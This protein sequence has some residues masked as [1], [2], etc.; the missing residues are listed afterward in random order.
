M[1]SKE[2]TNTHAQV[3][4]QWRNLV[5]TTAMTATERMCHTSSSPCLQCS[6]CTQSHPTE[7]N[8]S[9][10][11]LLGRQDLP[12]RS[13]LTLRLEVCKSVALKN[14]LVTIKWDSLGHDCE[15]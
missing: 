13:I 8:M 3:E 4:A 7:D 2:G 14:L 5:P 1:K 15:I 11:L 10:S 6:C 12:V 9:A